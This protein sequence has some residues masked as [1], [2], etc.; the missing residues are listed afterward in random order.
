[1]GEKSASNI[2]EALRKSKGRQLWNLLYGLGIR[3]VGAGAARLLADRFG[4]LDAIIAAGSEELQ[5][6]DD[7]GP[8][9][10]KS[11]VAFFANAENRDVIGRLRLSGLPFETEKAETVMADAFFAGKTFVLTGELKGMTRNEASDMI[12]TRGGKV[13]SSV[14]AKTDYV[15]VGSNPGS[16]HEKALQLGITILHEDEFKKRLG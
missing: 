12:R 3:H 1:M 11:I 9:M 2:L 14:S 15:L 8:V 5:S 13:V 4:S 16:K 7:M 10:A 6:I